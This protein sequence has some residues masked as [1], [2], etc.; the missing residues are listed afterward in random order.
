MI[1]THVHPTRDAADASVAAELRVL[2]RAEPRAVL[3]F[4]TGNTPIG[5]YRTL[6]ADRAAGRVSLA[7]ASSFNLDEYVGLDPEDPRRFGAWM[8]EQLFRHVDLPLA[9]AR[10]PDVDAVD[11][12]AA[13]RAY[14]AA[15]ASAGGLDWLVLGIG[16]NGHVGFNE[17]GSSVD[18]RTRVVELAETTRADAA[19]T[20]GGAE[21]VPR[22]AITMGVATILGAKRIRVLA[23][24]AAKAA[25]VRAC[26]HEPVSERCPATF[27]RGHPDVELHLDPESAALASP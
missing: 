6:A 3:G 11:L 17:P 5:L 10:F 20:F 9:R 22:R 19:R 14:E 21:N 8:R 24:G 12:D 2:L 7:L 27:L 23:F 15:L 13:A 18:S 4:A 26:L 25:I 16:R 1:R